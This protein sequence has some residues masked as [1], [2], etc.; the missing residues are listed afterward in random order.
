MFYDEDEYA[1]D[2]L[3]LENPFAYD[4]LFD[5]LFDQAVDALEK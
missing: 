3:E 2:L 1:G 5:Y 4:C